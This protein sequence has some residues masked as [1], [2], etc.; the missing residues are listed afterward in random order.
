MENPAKQIPKAIIAG[1]IAI[2]VVYLISAFGIGV[3]IPV[4]DLTVDSGI[5]DALAVMAPQNH[6][7]V[8]FSIAELPDDTPDPQGIVCDLTACPECGGRLE[9]DYCHL[10]HLGRARCTACG[11]TNPEAQY[12]MR[13]QATERTLS[14]A[15]NTLRQLR[16]G[17]TPAGCEAICA[18]LLPETTARGIAMSHASE[19]QKPAT[20]SEA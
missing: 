7:K 17:L 8:F 16:G 14:V 11:L 20:T 4:A 19:T 3:A 5:S 15:S 1:G 2:A 13:S 18:L 6:N 10:R 12:V 9:Y